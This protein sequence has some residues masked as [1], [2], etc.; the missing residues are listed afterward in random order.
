MFTYMP[1]RES[2][3]IKL[4][5]GFADRENQVNNRTPYK[6]NTIINNTEEMQKILFFR[7]VRILLKFPER[8][9]FMSRD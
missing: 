7:C 5:G 4:K 6:Y 9:R 8:T 2:D 1:D 3:A